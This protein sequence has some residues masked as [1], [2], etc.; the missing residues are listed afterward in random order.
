[1]RAVIAR[2]VEQLRRSP[3]AT[4]FGALLG[5]SLLWLYWPTLEDMARRWAHDPRYSH[6]YLVPLFGLYLL[7]SRRQ[8]GAGLGLRPTWWGLLILAAGLTVGLVGSIVFLPWLTEV[9]LLPILAGVAVLLGGWAALRWAWPSIAFLVFMLPMPFSLETALAHPL[10]R[11][12]TVASVWTLQTLGFPAHAEGNWIHIKQIPPLEVAEACSGLN[13]LMIF[14]ALSTAVAI[15]LRRPW[16]DK[17]VVL[18]SAIP[19]A[20]VCNI[21]RITVTGALSILVSPELAHRV[22]HDLAGWLMMPLALG[23]LWLE[24]KALSWVL[25]E[26]QVRGPVPVV[27]AISAL[28]AGLG[29]PA[30]PAPALGPPVAKADPSLQPSN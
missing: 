9:S 30:Q 25:V 5:L 10:Q 13:M 23:L 3:Q 16:L 18:L 11:V 12:G 29:L 20:L 2:T 24:L 17:V 21:I 22:F 7:W 27:R 19:I 28:Q 1:M 26:R 6:G 15:L 8:L 4:L 14:I